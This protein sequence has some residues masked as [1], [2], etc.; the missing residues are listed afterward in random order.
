MPRRQPLPGPQRAAA[1]G[2][3]MFPACFQPSARRGKSEI[4]AAWRRERE[5][6]REG[7]GEPDR[8]WL[9]QWDQWLPSVR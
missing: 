1:P 9:H 6:R 5:R 4:K 2:E 7:T 8:I 3:V